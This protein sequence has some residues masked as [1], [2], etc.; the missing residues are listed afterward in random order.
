MVDNLKQKAAKGIVWK[1]LGQGGTQFIQFISGIY[2]ARLLSPEDYGLVGMLA[3]FMGISGI[4]INS[5]FKATLIQKGAKA[6]HDDYTVVFYFN[7][8]ISIVFYFLIFFGAHW[9]AQFFNEPRLVIVA[10]V[11]GLNLILTSLGMIHQVIFEKK[12]NFRTLT[13]I[14]IIT[15]SISVGLGIVY[16]SKGFGVWALVIM[17]VSENLARTILF[18]ILNRW[19]PKLRF[20]FIVFK[21]LFAKGSQL[22]IAGILQQ[23]NQNIFSFVIGKFFTTADVGF[24]SQGQKLQ[25]RI[26]DFITLSIQG[27][28]FPVQTLMKDDLPRL[29]NAVR[30]N[31]MIT[32]LVA[33]PA[34][35]GIIVV[36]EPFI[37]LFLTEKWMQTVYYLQILAVAGM[38][39]V[40]RASA[41]SFLMALG[42]FNIIVRLNVLNIMLL[43]VII[44][45]GL[46]LDVDLK[47]LIFGKVIQEFIIF[48][49]TVY[50][51]NKIIAYNAL[52]IIKDIFPALFFSIFMGV[53]VYGLGMRFN[54]TFTILGI[55]VLFGI[56]T[57]ILLNSLFNRKMFAEVVNMAKS[58]RKK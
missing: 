39:Y 9:I 20:D 38:F 45:I 21:S 11:L 19:M 32:T 2:I 17:M 33:F 36:A 55:Q 6:T 34:S 24:Y 25:K 51:T 57:Y 47:L 16:A 1:F 54:I 37:Q 12:L 42:K 14:R 50:Y 52:E 41:S 3:I 8:A 31:L 29:K 28:M 44:T 49:V 53:I 23:L 48:I 46:M 35:V 40:V 5:G 13:K 43:I 58:F 30:K 27:V 15:V 4:F 56:L 22:L 18:W 7:T 10:R 26:G